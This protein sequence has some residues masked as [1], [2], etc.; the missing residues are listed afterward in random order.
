MVLPRAVRAGIDTPAPPPPIIPLPPAVMTEYTMTF[1]MDSRTIWTRYALG[2]INYSVSDFGNLPGTPSVKNSMARNAS[3]VGTFF[4]P[5][6]GITAGTKIG[7]LLA[8][9]LVN[10]E[11]VVEVIKSGKEDVAVYTGIWAKQCMALAE[12][13]N[14]LNPTQY[15]TDLLAESF[16]NLTAAW[17]RDFKARFSGDFA[18]DAVALDDIIKIG[19]TGVPDHLQVGYTSIADM[20]SRGIVAQF[21]L[22]FVK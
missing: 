22:S 9:V 21:P 20:L 4:T 17:V 16:I 10:G 12:Y 14:Q 2:M 5:Y 15:P 1:R 19:V 11:K 8:A 7:E 6:Y 13:L 18:A 3:A